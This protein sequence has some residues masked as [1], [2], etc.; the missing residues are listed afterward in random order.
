MVTVKK[1]SAAAVSKAEAKL[2]AETYSKLS[3]DAGNQAQSRRSKSPRQS[4][5]DKNAG[6]ELSET[7]LSPCRKAL[8]AVSI[9]LW[10]M[11]TGAS[12]DMG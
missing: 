9:W 12:C 2:R 11:K 7:Q 10:E 3:I 6:H 5:R 4:T 8:V 1:P